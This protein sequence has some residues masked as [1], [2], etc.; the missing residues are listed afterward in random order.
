MLRARTSTDLLRLA[1]LLDV[2]VI[3]GWRRGDVISNDHRLYLGM[4]GYGSPA[5]V[6]ERL[7]RAD[8]LLVLGCRLSE[9]TSFGYTIPTSDQRWAHVDVE[10][11]GG[12][13]GLPPPAITVQ[14]DARTFL[15]AAVTRLQGSVLDAAVVDARRLTNRGGPRGL[16]GGR[17][18]RRDGVDRTGRPPGAYHRDPSAG[19]A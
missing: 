1:E 5:A 4:A 3:A 8:A 18:R 14:S 16:G 15:R 2:P 19:A 7:E 17:R 13:D 12:R 10:P 11:I 9:I 6:R